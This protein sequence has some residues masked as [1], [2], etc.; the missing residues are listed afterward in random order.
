MTHYQTLIQEFGA[1]NGLCSS[2]TESA[3]IRAV[4]K[5]WRRSSRYNALGQMLL[6]NQRLDKLAASRMDFE[7]RGMLASSLFE[8]EAQ[9][10]AQNTNEDD[11]GGAVDRR[12]VLGEVAL[13]KKPV[14]LLPLDAEGLA[15][16]LNIPSFP[17]LISH[18]LYEQSHPELDM[19]LVEIPL[20]NCPAPEGRIRVYP[21][22]IATFYAPSNVSGIGG[23]FR[24]RIRAVSSWR[25]SIGRYDCVFVEHDPTLPGFRGLHAARVH[26]FF[27]LTTP[28]RRKYPCALVSWFHVIADEPCEETGMWVVEKD[29]DVHGVPIMSIIYIDTILRGAH[30][31]G[32][33][34]KDRVPKALALSPGESLDAFH[35]FYVNKYVNH[36]AHE[37]AY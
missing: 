21:S 3:H 10:V 8:A 16:H 22:A 30:L 35:Q 36:H 26:M 15:G 31:I 12:D 4:K 27:E 5:P 17:D 23:M 24:E 2:I 6:V 9:V 11:D 19:P 1:P 13:A 32:R 20:E 7:R 18:F 25:G 29:L 14:R 34:G 37:I 33:A 28:G